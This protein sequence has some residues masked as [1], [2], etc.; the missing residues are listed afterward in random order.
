MSLRA[1]VLLGLA[2]ST[3][4]IGSEGDGA[5]PAKAAEAARAPGSRVLQGGARHAPGG[6][7]P[8]SAR[9]AKWE[10]ASEEVC[11]GQEKRYVPCNEGDCKS[12]CVPVDCQYK[13]W[14]EWSSCDCTGLRARERDI[15]VPKNS[16]GKGCTGDFIETQ[17][18]TPNCYKPQNTCPEDVDCVWDE[19]SDWSGCT[20]RC[21]GGQKTRY[22]DIKVSPQGKGELCEPRPKS[23]VQPCQTQ[24]CDQH[25]VDGK[26]QDWS[27]WEGCTADCGGGVRWRH[28]KIAVEANACGKI[29][30]G[31]DKEFEACNQ[32]SCRAP[33]D[34]QWTTWAHWSDCSCPCDGVK[35]RS[36]EIG[37]HGEGGG[38]WCDDD[39]TQVAPCNVAQTTPGCEHP[40]APPVDCV[41]GVWGE[42]SHCSTLCGPGQTTRRRDIVTDAKNGGSP[43][44]GVLEA[45]AQCK[46]QLPCA[47][48]D[49]PPKPCLWGDWSDWGACDRC[50]GEQKRYRHITQM[51]QYGGD[52]CQPQASEEIGKCP[53]QCHDRFFCE[54]SAWEVVDTCSAACGP[55][56]K[57]EQRVLKP[58]L[59]Q[60]QQAQLG[61][62]AGSQ[63]RGLIENYGLLGEQAEGSDMEHVVLARRLEGASAGFLVG[64]VGMFGLWVFTAKRRA[65]PQG[66]GYRQVAT[67][68]ASPA[69]D[70][71]VRED[72][73]GHRGARGGSQRWLRTEATGGFE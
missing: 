70:E 46:D 33:V 41:L 19:W 4:G 24:P 43:C 64:A 8:S 12:N 17:S 1:L 15:G 59:K 28:R 56:F 16:C 3:A 53:R 63:T 27:S 65:S 69:L 39:S 55:G 31:N 51:P 45:S 20:A 67:A 32:V 57:S 2:A 73:L 26:W 71:Q 47:S 52:E 14:T 25:C 40:K 22:R 35:H 18:C 49:H 38:K 44:L 13:D 66:E 30:P 60:P 9:G 42:W 54:W 21:G 72:L 37:R 10:V 48:R 5:K 61:D 34:C 23:Q 62:D 11:N 50:G 7:G 6:A 29:A 58:T 68:D 36:R